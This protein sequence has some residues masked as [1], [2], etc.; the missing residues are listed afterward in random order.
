MKKNKVIAVILGVFCVSSIPAAI[1]AGSIGDGVGAL[2]LGAAFGFGAY[3]LWNKKAP[4]KFGEINYPPVTNYGPGESPRIHSKLSGHFLPEHQRRLSMIYRTHDHEDD[5][6]TVDD[7]LRF[8]YEPENEYDHEAIA[9]YH[10]SEGKI[11]YIQRH[12][13]REFKIN[14]GENGPYRTRL[15]IYKDPKEYWAEFDIWR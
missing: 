4:Q 5:Q 12:L 13:T 6:T 8:V 10:N 11:G 14:I 15:T 1:D 7:E 3:K 2:I 9:V